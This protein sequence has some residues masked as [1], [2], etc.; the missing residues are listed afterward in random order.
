MAVTFTVKV[1]TLVQPTVNVDAPDVPR[2]ILV[3]LRV[4]AHPAG[5]P[6]AVTETMPVNPYTGATAI[7]DVADEPG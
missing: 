3:R 1:A 4:E 2:V 5:A 6:V 7:V